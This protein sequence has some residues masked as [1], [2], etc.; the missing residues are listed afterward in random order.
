MMEKWLCKITRR[1]DEYSRHE[2]RIAPSHDAVVELVSYPIRGTTAGIKILL[3]DK[4]F[5]V[6]I[7]TKKEF[8]ISSRWQII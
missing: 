6:L 8:V 2:R 7:L 1:N 3:F 4:N 5:H